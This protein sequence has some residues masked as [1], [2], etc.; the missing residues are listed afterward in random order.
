MNI[1]SFI[2]GEKVGV[3]VGDS[4]GRVTNLVCIDLKSRSNQGDRRD[5]MRLFAH[6]VDEIHTR[7]NTTGRIVY[8]QPKP[9]GEAIKWCQIGVLEALT[10]SLME[11][12]GVTLNTI[13][14]LNFER[15]KVSEED[16]IDKAS[17]YVR[18]EEPLHYEEANAV[19][20]L[21]VSEA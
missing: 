21:R 20:L 3:A 8:E 18:R 15:R 9:A 14:R 13:N 1:V 17:L 5:M 6:V 7:Y 4:T 12:K 10:G 11:L 16:A 19:L 2:L